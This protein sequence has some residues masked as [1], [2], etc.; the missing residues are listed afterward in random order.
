MGALRGPAVGVFGVGLVAALASAFGYVLQHEGMQDVDV[1]LRHLR[2]VRRPL[3]GTLW[4]AGIG[5]M[6]VGQR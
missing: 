2:E 1:S 6:V 3:T 4:L 5:M